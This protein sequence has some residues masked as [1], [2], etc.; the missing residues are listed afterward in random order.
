MKITAINIEDGTLTTEAENGVRL[1]VT[2]TAEEIPI[3]QQLLH[4]CVIGVHSTLQKR[5]PDVKVS[6]E[7]RDPK[8]A[9]ALTRMMAGRPTLRVLN[10]G[11]ADDSEG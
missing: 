9:K 10:G 11:K 6:M 2:L 3:V 7:V 1:F 8:V 4:R 5:R